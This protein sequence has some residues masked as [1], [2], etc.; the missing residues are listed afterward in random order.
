MQ[1]MK[2][3]ESLITLPEQAEHDGPAV[4]DRFHRLHCGAHPRGRRGHS[5]PSTQPGQLILQNLLRTAAF[6]LNLMFLFETNRMPQL[7]S[8]LTHVQH[9]MFQKTYF[10]GSCSIHRTFSCS[11]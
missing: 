11:I 5:Q 3:R 1:R 2:I 7:G 10:V 4:A 8:N 9:V 6:I